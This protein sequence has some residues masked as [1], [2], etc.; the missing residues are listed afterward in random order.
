MTSYQTVPHLAL[1]EI[2]TDLDRVLGTLQ[3]VAN[4]MDTRYRRFQA[5][6]VRNIQ[7]FNE[8]QTTNKLP[9]WVVVI[10]ELADLMMTAPD[11]VQR[12]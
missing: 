8:K 2:V 10:D 11:Q 5:M 1:S 6:G 4:E 9:Y 12:L 7:G 3:A